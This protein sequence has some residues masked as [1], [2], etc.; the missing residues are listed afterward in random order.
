MVSLSF[1]VVSFIT[2]A[3]LVAVV[4]SSSSENPDWGAVEEPV[5][6]SGR[7]ISDFGVPPSGRGGSFVKS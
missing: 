5:A 6:S 1:G 7:F 2:P 3:P 4:P